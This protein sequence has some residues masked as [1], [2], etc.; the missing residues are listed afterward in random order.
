M[1]FQNVLSSDAGDFELAKPGT[2]MASDQP[3][4]FRRS[5]CRIVPGDVIGKVAVQEITHR[6]R[7]AKAALFN[8][9]IIALRHCG[10]HRLGV[11]A[12]LIRCQ[13]AIPA[14]RHPARSA[15][16]ITIVHNE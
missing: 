10:K 13:H 5:R 1:H 2:E 9:R 16:R 14:N 8:N 4:D 11:L 6:R 12:S 3:A 7:I 15:G